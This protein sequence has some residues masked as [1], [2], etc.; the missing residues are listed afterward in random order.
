MYVNHIAALVCLVIL[1]FVVLIAPHVSQ[2]LGLNDS[3]S[4]NDHHNLLS[5]GIKM[6]LNGLYEHS[7]TKRQY[8]LLSLARH[9]ETLEEM[10]VY[11]AQYGEKEVWVRPLTMWTQLVTIDDQLVPRFKLLEE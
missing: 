6:K 10:V 3:N 4:L 2:L 5:E 11:Q 8:V 1:F 7:K 9:S